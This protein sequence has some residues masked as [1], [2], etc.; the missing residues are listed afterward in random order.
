MTSDPLG[1]S[2]AAAAEALGISR[3]HF[4]DHVLPHLPC[5]YVGRRRVVLRRDL[6]WFLDGQLASPPKRPPSSEGAP[7]TISGT[8]RPATWSVRVVGQPAASIR[9]DKGDGPTK[10]WCPMGSTD[11]TTRAR[12]RGYLYGD[13][14]A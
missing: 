3:S 7:V 14:D 6:E 9:K 1:Y 12:V 13:R 10:G 11:T 8:V 4:Y 5:R 2:P